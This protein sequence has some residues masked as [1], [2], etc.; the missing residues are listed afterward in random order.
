[1]PTRVTTGSSS[2]QG[3]PFPANDVAGCGMQAGLLAPPSLIDGRGSPPPSR[4]NGRWSPTPGPSHVEP[5]II[6]VGPGHA[7]AQGDSASTVETTCA[8]PL[9]AGATGAAGASAAG[10]DVVALT[11]LNW[12]APAK[13]RAGWTQPQDIAHMKDQ[14]RTE[15]LA[16]HSPESVLRIHPGTRLFRMAP[17]AELADGKV[18]VAAQ[19]GQTEI[20]NHLKWVAR[21]RV[22]ESVVGTHMMDQYV[23]GKE[24]SD[25]DVRALASLEHSECF[26]PARMQAHEVSPNCVKVWISNAIWAQAVGHPDL[27]QVEI[28]L[29]ELPPGAQVYLLSAPERNLMGKA[30]NFVKSL[31]GKDPVRY[32]KKQLMVILP[33][34]T[35]GMTMVASPPKKTCP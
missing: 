30:R 6:G 18:I 1:M 17:A 14:C 13:F 22:L 21:D 2:V 10:D 16:T 35:T 29:R 24:R 26:K 7:R 33:E 3:G 12:Y 32:D 11:P 15:F 4:V 9:A 20:L 25:D 31:R 19:D 27:V 28:K 8:A 5:R 23:S 34:G